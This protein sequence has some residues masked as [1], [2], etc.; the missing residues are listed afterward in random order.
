MDPI[1]EHFKTLGAL[2]EWMENDEPWMLCH[3]CNSLQQMF[4]KKLVE[5][6]IR[7]DVEASLVWAQRINETKGIQERLELE[8]GTDGG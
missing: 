1:A 7:Q 2:L 8:T 6:A 3:I 4:G 5:A